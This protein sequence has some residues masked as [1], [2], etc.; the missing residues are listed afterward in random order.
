MQDQ[1]T[2]GRVAANPATSNAPNAALVSAVSAEKKNKDA[3]V[4]EWIGTAY[5]RVRAAHKKPQPHK[6]PSQRPPSQ[7]HVQRGRRW[8]V[9]RWNLTT[10]TVLR[11]WRPIALT[12]ALAPFRRHEIAIGAML[13]AA[14]SALWFAQ[15]QNLS[16]PGPEAA[17]AAHSTPAV[18]QLELSAE[19][20]AKDIHAEQD[21]KITIPEAAEQAKAA[22]RLAEETQAQLAREQEARDA[23]EARAK[24]LSEDL[25]RQAEARETAE[26]ER[27][28]S[29]AALEAERAARDQAE[30]AAKSAKED[31]D[32]A[33]AHD[34][35][36]A[37]PAPAVSMPVVPVTSPP[38]VAIAAAE[39]EKPL[40][41]PAAPVIE[42]RAA[43]K[44]ANPA[45]KFSG[46]AAAVL[47][48]GEK[49]F[50]KGDLEA[51]RQN[52]ARAVKM[53]SPEGA[54]ALG[55]TFDPV[56]LANAGLKLGGDPA[57]A[58]QWYRRAFE[59]AQLQRRGGQ[60]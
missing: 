57:R 50:G 56:S 21:K 31:F 30:Q 42:A 9:R 36:S 10:R 48:E 40:A 60:P 28:K 3:E 35:A 41:Q 16:E 18:A 25:A 5:G 39:P 49:L 45:P 29:V 26:R 34:A 52:F 58:R 20:M 4:L 2:L 19:P 15:G 14:M 54:L 32:R 6:R 23:A 37:P 24:K 53:G 12:G 59:L 44:T 7:A 22:T 38:P 17:L 1:S 46:P 8:T 47:A 43:V 13:V 51:A 27:A 33:A 11:R 55:N